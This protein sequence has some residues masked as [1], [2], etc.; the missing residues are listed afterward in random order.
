[1]LILDQTFVILAAGFGS[2]MNS[3]TVSI[4]KPLMKFGGNRPLIDY[5][6]YNIV[7]NFPK[8]TRILIVT[9]Y[10]K[11]LINDYIHHLEQLFPCELLCLVAP[12]YKQGNGHSLL[13]LESSITEHFYLTMCD[14]LFEETIYQKL[15][16]GANKRAD[17]SLC[18]D[19]TPDPNIQVDDA[20]KVVLNQEDRIIQIGKNLLNWNAFDTGLFF[21]SPL[22]FKR[23]R[24]VS[25]KYLTL[26]HGVSE[27]IRCGDYVKGVDVSGY[28]WADIDTYT[29]LQHAETRLLDHVSPALSDHKIA[30][31]PFDIYPY[32]L[33]ENTEAHEN[34]HIGDA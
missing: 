16:M 15:Q 28:A 3:Q 13:S 24:Q 19:R 6:L 34:S 18:V 26:T 31:S 10:K 4:P 32:I 9:G 5:I 11:D 2:R 21:L 1:V 20:T 30:H 17:L 7:D 27:M 29:D 8:V 25:K 33:S 14:H 23:L 12:N 22:I